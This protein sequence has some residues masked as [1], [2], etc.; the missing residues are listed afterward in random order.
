[1]MRS[2]FAGVSGLRNHQIKMDVIGN[3]IANV[4]TVGFK[5]GRV[6]FQ[7]SLNQFLRGASSPQS[8]R[9]G[10]NALQVGLGVNIASID[11]IHTQG[12]LQNTGKISDVAIQGDGFLILGDGTGQFFTRAGNLSL[13]ADGRLVYPSNG[14][15]IQGWMSDISGVIN[16]NSP[17]TGIQLPIG[18]NIS[19]SATT[20]IGFKGNFAASTCGDLTYNESTVDV[21]NNRSVTLSYV[22]TPTSIYNQYEYTI[23]LNNGTISGGGS[24]TIT[25]DGDGTVLSATP[26]VPFTITGTG[27]YDITLTPPTAGQNDGGSFSAVVGSTPPVTVT[28]TGD[29]TPPLSLTTQTL[30]Y[31]SLGQG[32]TFTT[33]A[34]KTAVNTWAWETTSETGDV[35]G[36]GTLLFSSTGKLISSTAGTI[37]YTPTGANTMGITPD[38][39]NISQYDSAESTFSSPDQDGFTM[40]QL[41]SFNIDK[42]G[43]IIGVFS[44]G[45]S[46]TLAQIAVA[47]FNNPSGLLRSG[48]SMFAVSANSG[49]AQIGQAGSNGRGYITPAALEMSNV[50][51][52][53]EF[54]DM[55][56]TQR[57]FQAN[58]RI[59]TT[60]DEML[61][62]LVGLKR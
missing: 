5:S 25:L 22:L 38:F 8:G 51:L 46:Q 17:V 58:S 10:I 7:D 43:Q 42:I 32:H 45:R 27:G 24:G 28:I 52:S 57:G 18:Q 50:D 55:I 41:E 39:S 1:M 35:L 6:T 16:T 40:G 4:N 30:V 2:M 14:L 20:T 3:N 37:T 44:N 60:S 23:S 56:V 15:M 31:D 53:Q 59:I 9:G 12:N 21:G 49:T 62:E 13:E 48:E 26:A 36:S 34:D 47:N 11:V 19:P 61:Q 54:T 33:T 29:F